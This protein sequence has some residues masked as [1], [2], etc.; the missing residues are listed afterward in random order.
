MLLKTEF[1]IARIYS[2]KSTMENDKI[3]IFD[4]HLANL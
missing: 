3:I 4:R 2:R 1:V